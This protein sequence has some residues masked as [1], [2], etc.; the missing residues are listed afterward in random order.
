MGWADLKNGELLR[1]AEEAGVEVFVTADQSL[2]DEQNLTGRRLAIVALSA[3]TGRS[4]RATSQ[5]PAA[6]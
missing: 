4:S 1:T 5:I 2:V 6:N 3:I